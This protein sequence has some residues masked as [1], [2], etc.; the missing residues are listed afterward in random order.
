MVLGVNGDKSPPSCTKP[1][2]KMTACNLICNMIH[3]SDATSAMKMLQT[4]MESL[5]LVI[6]NKPSSPQPGKK[7][8]LYLL[9]VC[10]SPIVLGLDAFRK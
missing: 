3:D 9:D 4:K 10:F 1:Y 2:D 8:T 6:G 5:T 7:L